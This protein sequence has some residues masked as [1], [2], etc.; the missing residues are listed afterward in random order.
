MNIRLLVSELSR[1]CRGFALDRRGVSS[2]EFAILLPVMLTMY[3]GSVEVTD[4]ISADRKVTLV[5]NTVAEIASQYSTVAASDVSNIMS[6]AASVLS[7]FSV[8][9]VKVTLSSV[10]IDA[11][12]K[13]TVD[14]SAT[15]NGAVRSG[16]VTTSLP[17]SLLIANTSVLWGE[18]T[19][20][21]K[22]L[23]GYVI[24]GTMPLY[25]AIFIRP[26]LSTCVY[27]PGVSTLCTS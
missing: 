10:Y 1:R 27:Y 25:N 3:F 9:N 7:P 22:P 2:I 8:A 21:Y 4:A 14:W 5:S 18:A 17:S 6:A 15:L 16:V 13:A 11:N 24:T 20:N 23:I 26:R 12:L 19:Y